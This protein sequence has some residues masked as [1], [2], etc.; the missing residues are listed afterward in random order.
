MKKSLTL[1]VVH[2]QVDNPKWSDISGHNANDVWIL[3][4]TAGPS[5]YVQVKKATPIFSPVDSTVEKSQAEIEQKRYSQ[6]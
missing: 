1:M 3:V 4:T 2:L 6:K 5:A